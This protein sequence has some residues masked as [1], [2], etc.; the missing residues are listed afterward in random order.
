MISLNFEQYYNDD[1]LNTGFSLFIVKDESNPEGHITK[2]KVAE[3]INFL[4][5]KGSVPRLNLDPV[6]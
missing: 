2:R 4:V 5:F 3:I 1:I 6:K